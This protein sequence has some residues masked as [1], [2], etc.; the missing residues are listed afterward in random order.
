MTATRKDTAFLCS[1]SY[2]ALDHPSGDGL[3]IVERARHGHM[4][5]EVFESGLLQRAIWR[6]VE[7]IRFAE[8]P[9]QL[10][11]FEIN[12]D[13]APHAFDAVTSIPALGINDVQV[14]VGLLAISDVVGCRKSRLA[15][16]PIAR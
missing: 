5:L 13:T 2:S 9:L 15:G 11:P 14:H 10:Q 1:R 7:S 16:R 8:Q 12:V 4:G 6:D 3:M